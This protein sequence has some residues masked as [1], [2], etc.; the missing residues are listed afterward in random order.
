METKKNIAWI[1]SAIALGGVAMHSLASEE[2]DQIE[3]IK[4]AT[5]AESHDTD[6]AP[7][8]EVVNPL[9]QMQTEQQELSTV[10]SLEQQRLRN[11]LLQMELEKQRLQAESGLRSARQ[12]A[13][14]SEMRGEMERLQTE[15]SLRQARLDAELQA[16]RLQMSKMQT[17]KQLEDAERESALTDLRAES[18]RLQAENNLMQTRMLREQ[19]EAQAEL[20][21]YQLMMQEL[22]TK[23]QLRMTKDQVES[24]VLTDIDYTSMPK[25]G[26]TLYITDRRISMNGPIIGGTAQY[27]TDRIHYYNNIDSEKPI[28]IVIDDCPGGSVME[29]YR[30]VQAMQE[31]DAPVHVVVKSFAASMAAVITT[32]ADHSYAY[33]NAI[34]LHHQMSSG[35]RGNLTQQAESLENSFEWAKRLAEPVAKKM[36]VT[37]DEFVEQM[38]ENNSDGDWEEFADEAKKLKWVNDVITEIREVGMR[39]QPKSAAPSPFFFFFQAEEQGYKRD[40]RGEWYIELPPLRPYDHYFIH[41]AGNRYRW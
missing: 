23:H 4:T 39:S 30:I 22:E 14:L 36:G 3:V 34:I 38:Y 27:V 33:P 16:L 40:D 31:S 7:V 17:M 13:Q 20:T 18:S 32:L 5:A 19:T 28:F 21:R 11:E 24:F 37:Y 15:S 25:Q 12:Q 6:D 2:S 26:D 29:G 10:Y 8:E 9:E 35:M 1:L 41:G